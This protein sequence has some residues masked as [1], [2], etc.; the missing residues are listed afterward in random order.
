MRDFEK[1]LLVAAH[2]IA[3]NQ[4][5]DAIFTGRTRWC[6]YQQMEVGAM[7]AKTWV[8]HRG[9]GEHLRLPGSPEA[10][11][12]APGER[13]LNG[14]TSTPAGSQAEHAR[15]D[16]SVSTGPGDNHADT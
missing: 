10:K 7:Q 12:A 5:A 14:E 8:G 4:R 11:Q 16:R 13:A 1:C 3:W 2:G 15:P 6:L 9:L